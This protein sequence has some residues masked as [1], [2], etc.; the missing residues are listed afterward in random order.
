MSSETV[1]TIIFA[2]SGMIAAL[3]YLSVTFTRRLDALDRQ[4]KES[5]DE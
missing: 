4:M 3:I 2:H 1:S 5:S